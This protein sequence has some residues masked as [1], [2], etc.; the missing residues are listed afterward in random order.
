MV[1]CRNRLGVEGLGKRWGVGSGREV[2]AEVGWEPG[3]KVGGRSAGA[4]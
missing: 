4:K 1:G 3:W 2:G